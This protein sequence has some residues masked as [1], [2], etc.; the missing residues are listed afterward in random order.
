V[1]V[2]GV[3]A[4]APLPRGAGAAGGVVVVVPPLP[5]VVVVVVPPL[6]A[7]VVVV[8]PPPGVA[9]LP[10]ELGPLSSTLSVSI[11]KSTSS[12]RMI[13]ATN[14]RS[15]MSITAGPLLPA[16]VHAEKAGEPAIQNK[17]GNLYRHVIG[18]R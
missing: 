16:S 13:K 9:P 4:G 14:T 6:G 1:V 11:I 10:D 18:E 5:G 12:A 3:D 7:V 17:L 15:T 2:L 8:V